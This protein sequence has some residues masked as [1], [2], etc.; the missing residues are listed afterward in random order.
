[1]HNFLLTCHQVP[2]II[3]DTLTLYYW[4]VDEDHIDNL[5]CILISLHI[6]CILLTNI[7]HHLLWKIISATRAHSG[8]VDSLVSACLIQPASCEF[9]SGRYSW[10]GFRHSY[11]T[12]PSCSD[13]QV[14]LGLLGFQH[15]K[16]RLEIRLGTL[17]KSVMHLAQSREFSCWTCGRRKSSAGHLFSRSPRKPRQNT[18]KPVTGYLVFSFLWIFIYISQNCR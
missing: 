10:F 4:L 7:L 2:W 3:F 18:R 1:M 5:I 17:C 12:K 13:A 16:F 14:F 15:G 6:A 11:V 9:H 8:W